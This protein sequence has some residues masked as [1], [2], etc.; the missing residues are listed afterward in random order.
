MNY[1]RTSHLIFLTS[2]EVLRHIGVSL[3]LKWKN[4]VREIAY[5][6]VRRGERDPHTKQFSMSLYLW[7]S[8]LNRQE[9]VYALGRVCMCIKVL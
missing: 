7:I 8:V 3:H 1:I 5:F 6:L 2:A 9:W 4:S